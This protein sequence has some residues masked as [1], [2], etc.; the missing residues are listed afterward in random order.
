[1]NNLLN[2]VDK[3]NLLN[4]DEITVYYYCLAITLMLLFSGQN[5]NAI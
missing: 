5:L 1:M 3:Q 2:E 4:K